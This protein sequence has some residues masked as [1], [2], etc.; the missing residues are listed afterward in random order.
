MSFVAIAVYAN[1]CK[2]EKSRKEAVEK[3]TKRVFITAEKL[4]RDHS[5]SVNYIFHVL[6]TPRVERRHIPLNPSPGEKTLLHNAS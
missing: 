4:S 5:I 2:P 6:I 1:K 3:L